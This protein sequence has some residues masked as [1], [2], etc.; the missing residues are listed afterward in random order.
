MT[1]CY[2][3]T[4]NPGY[5]RNRVLHQG[6]VQNGVNVIE[7]NSRSPGLQKYIALWRQGRTLRGRCDVLL[8]GFPGA[9]VMPLAWLVGQRLGVPVV[10][11]AFTSQYDAMVNARKQVRPGS[12][13]AGYFRWLDRLS[14]RLADLVL[15]DTNAHVDYLAQLTGLPRDKFHHV[16]VGTD[17]TE[18]PSATVPAAPV[19]KFLVHFHGHYSSFQGVDVIVRTAHLLRSE[20][21]HFRLVG[22]GQKYPE[23]VSL[24]RDL[25]V[26]N[27]E[28]IPDVDYPT[29]AGYIGQ[30][31]LCLG[32][33]GGGNP[34]PVIPNKII[35]AIAMGKPVLT[36]HLPAMDELLTGGVN[37]VFCIPGDP[38][39]LAAKILALAKDPGRRARI[40][41]AGRMLYEQRLTPK[42]IGSDL[43]EILSLRGVPH[44]GTTKQPPQ[45]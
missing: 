21:I 43:L 19:G 36:G 33:F 10:F 18:F 38:D 27:V 17:I 26:A 5:S 6:L 4:Y 15:F 34:R 8:V 37:V 25:G 42:R 3:G 14:C 13:R 29:L 39:D 41:A 11:D 24:A 20:P 40:G 31:D 35:E 30:S 2:F 23:I 28:F 22:R 1:V 32:I 12:L 45:T 7:C 44:G 9:T 16:Y